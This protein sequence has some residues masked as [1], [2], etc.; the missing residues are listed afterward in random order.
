MVNKYGLNVDN[1]VFVIDSP[2]IAFMVSILSEGKPV[3]IVMEKKK[4]LETENGNELLMKFARSCINIKDIKIVNL[5]HRFYI[6]IKDIRKI[7]NIR[8]ETYNLYNEYSNDTVFIGASTSTFMRGLKCNPERIIYLHHGMTDL[9]RRE[10]EEKNRRGIKSAIKKLLVGK[11]MGLPHSTWC[12]F[13]PQR[14]FSLC[15]LN[16]DEEVWLNIYDFKSEKMRKALAFLDN[17][18]D[19]KNNVLFFPVIEGH[20]RLGVNSDV[21]S[22]DKFNYNFLC[23]YINFDRDR[24]FIKYHPWIYRT[25]NNMK[26]NLLNMLKDTGIEVYDI[27][28]MIP[29]EVGGVLVPTEVIC[30][31]MKIDRMI[32]EDT[33]TIWY[34]TGNKNIEKILDI[35]SISAEKRGLMLHCYEQLKKKC[36]T[37]D[38]TFHV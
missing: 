25:N 2:V 14:A 5:S 24:V 28:A 1:T 38:I 34:L 15:N 16:N 7:W 17:Y 32:A 11:L 12:N 20:T 27:A 9:F 26:S 19:G 10:D 21:T 37:T 8:Q 23:R 29:D 35:T 3:T 33:S 13:W 18:D 31:Y 6:G 36:D 30:K 4:G 22:F